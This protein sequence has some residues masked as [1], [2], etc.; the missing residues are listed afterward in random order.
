MAMSVMKRALKDFLKRTTFNV[1]R[2]TER[3]GVHI[4]PVHYYSP[5]PNLAQLRHT[6]SQWAVRSD[7]PGINVDVENQLQNL[8][9]M[10]VAYEPEYRD[11]RI[12]NEG[13]ANRCGPGYGPV[14]A[15]ALHGFLR[16]VKPRQIIEVGSGVSTHCMTTALAMNEQEG[17]PA[18]TLR[19]IEPYPSSWLQQ[20]RGFS[21][22]KKKVQQVSPEVFQELQSGDFLFI[23]SSHTLKPGCDVNYLFL[24]VLPR[25]NKGVYVH[26]HDIYLP[27]DY[28][29]EVLKTFLHASETSLLRAWLIG[30]THVEIIFALSMLFYDRPDD[31]RK[32]FPTF[33]P[34]AGQNGMVD[35]RVKPFDRAPGHFPSA[36]YLRTC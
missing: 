30:N 2:L 31:L 13:V 4:T 27:Y 19:C 21:L 15:Q 35:D 8:H 18:S 34:Q 1:G 29:R 16:H 22:I 33:E 9:D 26:I 6:Q 17:A 14:E 3:I 7:L 5:L 23:D 24:E 12:F 28:Q 11:N 20:A 25:L 36:I 10:C 32:I